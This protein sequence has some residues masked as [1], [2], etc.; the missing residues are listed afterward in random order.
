MAAQ[1]YSEMLKI[2]KS[3]KAMTVLISILTVINVGLVG[4]TLLK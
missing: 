2:N 4:Y 3:M 1:H